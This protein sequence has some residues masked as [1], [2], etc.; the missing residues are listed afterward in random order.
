MKDRRFFSIIGIG[1]L[2]VVLLMGVGCRKT[3]SNR[4]VATINDEKIMLDEFHVYFHGIKQY[5]EQSGGSDIWDTD[6]EG[7]TAEEVAKDRT[8][9]TIASVKFATQKAKELDL[10]LTPQEEETAKIEAENITTDIGQKQLEKMGTTESKIF[11]IMEDKAFYTKVFD[12]LTKNFT[13]NEEEL[14]Y[15]YN[16]QKISLLEFR[17]K[18]IILKTHELSDNKLIA[19]PESVQVE[20]KQKAEMALE[21]AKMGENFDELVREYT[22]DQIGKQNNGEYRFQIGEMK[23][24]PQLEETALRLEPGEISD[25]IETPFGYHIIKLEERI[26][27][28]T[29]KLEQLRSQLQEYI[30]TMKK[31]DIF[32]Q[33]F[34]KWRNKAVIQK[35]DAVWNEIRIERTGSTNP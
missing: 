6:F 21:R 22:Q 11:K 4:L 2:L 5:F 1:V 34:E 12:E 35:N 28:D 7:K 18:D 13:L 19:L 23:D 27:P 3:E 9:N 8:L 25:I 16:Q 31:L 24:Q 33:E 14:D 29:Q 30:T 10:Q 26:E 32:N 17:I 20:A 15:Y